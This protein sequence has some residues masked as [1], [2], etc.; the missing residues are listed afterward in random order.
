MLCAAIWGNSWTPSSRFYAQVLLVYSCCN[1]AGTL[2][3]LGPALGAI[4]DLSEAFYTLFL[5]I[6]KLEICYIYL[7][8]FYFYLLANGERM[9]IVPTLNLALPTVPHSMYDCENGENLGETLTCVCHHK[10]TTS[11]NSNTRYLQNSCR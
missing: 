11:F 6:L 10:K 7:S 5:L 3:G 1:K 4:L 2:S 8:N 9:P